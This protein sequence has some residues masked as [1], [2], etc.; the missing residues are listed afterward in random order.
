MILKHRESGTVEFVLDLESVETPH[1][2]GRDCRRGA[3]EGRAPLFVEG[4]RDEASEP[5]SQG[6]IRSA[7]MKTAD[8]EKGTSCS[9][10]IPGADSSWLRSS[11]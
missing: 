1:L 9:V 2:V 11:E 3:E 4:L 8:T 6:K 5:V 10:I 7:S